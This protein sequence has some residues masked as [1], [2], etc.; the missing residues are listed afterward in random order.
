M[1]ISVC[2]EGF[3]GVACNKTCGN[4]RDVKTCHH[5]KGA[6]LSG[7]DA[8][9]WG[10]LCKTRGYYLYGNMSALINKYDKCNN[11]FSSN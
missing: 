4:C 11:I 9:Y 1:F 6:C 7:C 10:L 3:Y 8:G 5:V 2:P